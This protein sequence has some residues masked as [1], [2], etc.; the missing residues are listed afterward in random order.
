MFPSL[1]WGDERL[2]TD[3]ER[4]E[5]YNDKRAY[6]VLPIKQYDFIFSSIKK[7]FPFGW[8]WKENPSKYKEYDYETNSSIYESTGGKSIEMKAIFIKTFNY[9]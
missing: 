8:T 3:K 7:E 4:N 9:E 1:S 6:D 5:S 2:S